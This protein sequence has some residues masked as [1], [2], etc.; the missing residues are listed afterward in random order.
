M[1]NRTMLICAGLV[2]FV[3][4]LHFSLGDKPKRIV[5]SSKPAATKPLPAQAPTVEP[6]NK[7]PRF[8]KPK[9]RK[10]GQNDYEPSNLSAVDRDKLTHIVRLYASWPGNTPTETLLNRLKREQPFLSK[11]VIHTIEEQWSN[12]P[13]TF[14]LE[15]TA[16]NVAPS[17]VATGQNANEAEVTALV[18]LL[19]HFTPVSKSAYSER[20]TQPYTIRLQNVRGKWTVVEITTQSQSASVG[21]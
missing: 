13:L 2:V 9:S 6:T 10:P 4:F 20:A 17:V 14:K 21:A 11:Q 16:V 5:R 1:R 12:T 7:A 15:V 8:D 19:K 3:L 18:G